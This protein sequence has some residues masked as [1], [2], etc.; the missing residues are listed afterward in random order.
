MSIAIAVEPGTGARRGRGAALLAAALAL[1]SPPATAWAAGPAAPAVVTPANRAWE[2]FGLADRTLVHGDLSRPACASTSL[3]RPRADTSVPPH[4]VPVDRAYV[5]LSGAL[6]VGVGKEWDEHRLRKLSPGSFWY[7]PAR[8]S[9]FGR[10]DEEVVLQVDVVH[11]AEGCPLPAEP[12]F[13]SPEQIRWEESAGGRRAVLLGNPAA[14]RC[15]SV[16]R[17]RL[18][19]SPPPEPRAAPD[20]SLRVCTVLSGGLQGFPSPGASPE[21]HPA[22]PAGSLV[23]LPAGSCGALPATEE[24]VVQEETIAETRRACAR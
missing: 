6:R 9:T 24:A 18:L 5:V 23:V 8:T 2:P 1:A 12:L 17:F 11:G 16:V 3:I 10:A 14:P 22:L 20:P 13:L 21:R 15:P 4:A 19:P 7:V